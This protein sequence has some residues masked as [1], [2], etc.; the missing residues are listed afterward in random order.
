MNRLKTVSFPDG[1]GDQVFTYEPD[2]LVREI[3]TNNDAGVVTTNSYTYNRRRLIT[4][5]SILL[6]G[7][8]ALYFGYGYNRNGILASNVYPSNTGVNYA[9]NALGQSTQVGSY[10]TG[11]SYHPNGAVAGF[12]YGNGIIHSM[13]Q[14]G[15]RKPARS[16]DVGGQVRL[17]FS[18][19]TTAMEMS[20]R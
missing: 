12:T 8:P 4:G 14:N 5:E 18:S 2:G 20:H 11:V 19:L 7:R 10:A 15:R 9:P 6:P 13:V 1:R 17:T 3:S 16:T